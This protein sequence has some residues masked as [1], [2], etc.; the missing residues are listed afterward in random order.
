MRWTEKKSPT[1]GESR[2]IKRFLFIPKGLPRSICDETI[3]WRWLEKAIIQ[4]KWKICSAY[5]GDKPIDCEGWFNV[6]WA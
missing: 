1:I 4:Q 2:I 5:F 3:E 6:S